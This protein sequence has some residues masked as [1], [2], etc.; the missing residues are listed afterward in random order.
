VKYDLKTE[1]SW[2]GWIFPGSYKGAKT[3]TT[4]GLVGTL[5]ILEPGLTTEALV[6]TTKADLYCFYGKQRAAELYESRRAVSARTAAV[7]DVQ[8]LESN[9]IENLAGVK[10]TSDAIKPL[11]MGYKAVE[12]GNLKLARKALAGAYLVYK[13]V[14]APGIADVKDVGAHGS[15]ILDLATFHRFSDERRRGMF[16]EGDILCAGTRAT[17]SYFTTYHLRLKNNCFSQLWSALEKLGLDPSAG[18]LWDLIPYSFVVDWFVP[19][20]D[21]LRTIDAYNSLVC[22]RDILGRIES[23]KVLW[24]VEEHELKD[25]FDGNICSNGL[26]IE[27]SWYDRRVYSDVGIIDPI[28]INS[29]DNGLSVSQMAQ[30]AALLTQYKR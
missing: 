5:L 7:R 13:Y 21:S 8:A 25:M 29:D 28:V 15:R 2:F 26:P 17:L 22:N 6:D 19:V 18:Q 16:T 30:G 11:L 24:P 9:W 20:G 14:I 10:G 27:Y 1:L 4:T 12:K 23:Y 3:V